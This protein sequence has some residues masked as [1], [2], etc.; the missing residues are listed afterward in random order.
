M[1]LFANHSSTTPW[2]QRNKSSYI[3][4]LFT[5]ILSTIL[6]F[7]RSLSSSRLVH[8]CILWPSHEKYN[9]YPS[10]V[11]HCEP[12]HH[13]FFHEEILEHLVHSVPFITAV[14]TNAII[15]IKI[16]Q[17]LTRPSPGQNGNKLGKRR[18]TWMLLANSIIF[19][20]C[21]APRN[22]S[23]DFWETYK[24]FTW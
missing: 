14:I 15:N 10:L 13:F 12:I 3:L 21:L 2:R 17:R 20:F 11:R 1:L 16:L 19:F 23:S 5:W 9:Y 4:T 24:A 18:I 7:F 8:E 22:F 6:C